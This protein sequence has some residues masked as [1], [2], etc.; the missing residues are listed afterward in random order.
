MARSESY[1]IRP[2]ALT[3]DC[4]TCNFGNI[5]CSFGGQGRIRNEVAAGRA[6]AQA[7]GADL[8]FVRLSLHATLAS[9][10]V[11]LR[12]LDAQQDLLRHTVEA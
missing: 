11:L 12:G 2:A 9:T 8:A 4:S 10:Y 1:A 7:T 3:V 5:G 6:A